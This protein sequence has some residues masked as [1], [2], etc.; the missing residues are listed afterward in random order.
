LR[1]R[2][3]GPSWACREIWRSGPRRLRSAALS[4]GDAQ[5]KVGLPGGSKTLGSLNTTEVTSKTMVFDWRR[6]TNASLLI[7]I[8]TPSSLC[9]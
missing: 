7:G 9:N 1:P 2:S 6:T 4:T 8:K 3:G 5:L